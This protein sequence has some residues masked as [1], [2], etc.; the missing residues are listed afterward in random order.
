MPYRAAT[1]NVQRI[2]YRIPL[3]NITLTVDGF[4][5]QEERPY[6]QQQMWNGCW[7][8]LPLDKKPC[9]LQIRCRVAAAMRNALLVVL[10]AALNHQTTY[11]FTL[12]GTGFSSLKLTGYKLQNEDGTALCHVVLEFIG[13]AG[14]PVL[15]P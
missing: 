14:D 5:L 6:E 2:T 12:G 11:A 3:D 8:E 10:R 13:V 7:Y 4:T 9:H 1:A 15:Q